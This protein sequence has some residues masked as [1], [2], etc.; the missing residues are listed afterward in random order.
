M[1]A[2]VEERFAGV[3]ARSARPRGDGGVVRARRRP[4]VEPH[5]SRTWPPAP[6]GGKRLGRFRK[7][8]GRGSLPSAVYARL[9]RDAA[10][11]RT[12]G[13]TAC[14]LR[15][16]LAGGNLPRLNAMPTELPAA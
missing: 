6:A 7:G 8:G 11:A 16:P 12:S 13:V 10:G 5:Q 15:Y 9:R 1:D 14:R 4:L 2:L 3:R